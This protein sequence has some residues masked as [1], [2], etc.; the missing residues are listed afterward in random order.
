LQR[1]EAD[2]AAAQAAQTRELQT[3]VAARHAGDT[4]AA[5]AALAAAQTA[6]A[7]GET[8]RKDAGELLKATQPAT[9]AS[10]A[11]HVFITFILRYLPHG[12]IGLLVAAFFAA[13]LNSK[14]AELSALASCSTVDF[15]RPLFAA[16]AAES[17]SVLVSK[18]FTAF[19]GLVAI[20][21]ALG[22]NL[23]ENI[24]QAANI[25]GSLFYGPVLGLFLLAFF[26]KRVGG[27][28]AFWGAVGAQ[29]AVLSLYGAGKAY[30]AWEI[31][32]LWFNLIG[33]VLCV[34][35][36]LALQAVLRGQDSTGDGHL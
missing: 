5:Q 12:L 21:A 1:V 17:R 22:A 36:S 7:Q 19:W 11:D 15:W 31:A 8:A 27:T 6:H 16:G 20:V 35:F 2:F 18:C 29:V 32:Y 26:T 28:A 23:V 33:P 25:V 30:P 13:A 34:G 14:A 3:W 24:V 9:T 4:P 10:E